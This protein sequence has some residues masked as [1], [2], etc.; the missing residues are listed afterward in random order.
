MS[1]TQV[2]E[3][4]FEYSEQLVDSPIITSNTFNRI[5]IGSLLNLDS[6]NYAIVIFV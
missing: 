2:T 5:N 4:A 3:F 1:S 6:I